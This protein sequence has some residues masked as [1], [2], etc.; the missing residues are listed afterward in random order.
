MIIHNVDKSFLDINKSFPFLNINKS[1]ID[2]NN[3]FINVNESCHLL[4][5]R[6]DLLLNDFLIL[7]N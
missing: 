7:R 5:L 4:I 3:S 2:I 6:I 1:F